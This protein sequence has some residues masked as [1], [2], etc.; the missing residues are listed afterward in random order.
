[1]AKFMFVCVAD[2]GGERAT[3]AVVVVLIKFLGDNDLQTLFQASGATVTTT[4]S[5]EKSWDVH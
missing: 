3:V 2:F 1:M 5:W 4:K